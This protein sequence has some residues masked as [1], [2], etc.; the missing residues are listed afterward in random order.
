MEPDSFRQFFDRKRT[1]GID[2]PVSGFVSAPGGDD[3][4]VRS[5]EL[6]H[7]SVNRNVPHSALTSASGN[8]VRIS[9]MEITGR[10][11]KK[12][13]MHA[14]NRPMV[15]MKVIQSQRVG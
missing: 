15:P 8:K 4:A 14:A 6:R 2:L 3:Y 1:I 11:R 13:N 7:Q 5:I 10:M 9:K 12:R